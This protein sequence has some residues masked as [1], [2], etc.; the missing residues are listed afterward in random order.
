MSI[1]Q[2]F[3]GEYARI[4]FRFRYTF[5]KYARLQTNNDTGFDA[6]YQLTIFYGGSF[7][8]RTVDSGS[9]DRGSNPCPPVYFKN[10]NVLNK[11][12]E[13]RS[14]VTGEDEP[15]FSSRGVGESSPSEDRL[16]EF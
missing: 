14:F 5:K 6:L 8:G 9:T 3:Y 12:L 1:W 11:N 10:S 15:R 4:V 13:S 7:N 2:S 16:D